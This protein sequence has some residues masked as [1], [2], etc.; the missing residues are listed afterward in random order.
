MVN[1]IKIGL[2]GW[3]KRSECLPCEHEHWVQIHSTH[4]KS[5]ACLHKPVNGSM[6]RVQRDT[7]FQSN[8]MERYK[9]RHPKSYSRLLCAPASHCTHHCYPLERRTIKIGACTQTCNFTKIIHESHSKWRL[10]APFPVSYCVQ[11][12]MQLR[13]ISWGL[14]HSLLH[15]VPGPLNPRA[16]RSARSEAATSSKPNEHTSITKTAASTSGRDGFNKKV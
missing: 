10:P 4:I 11:N 3:A 2:E 6:L 16:S 8:N 5:Q 9:N 15:L 12:A 1:N 13:S 14:L 7:L